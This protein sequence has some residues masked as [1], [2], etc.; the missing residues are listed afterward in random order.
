M[1]VA[2][3]KVS[4]GEAQETAP[5]VSRAMTLT[6]LTRSQDGSGSLRSLVIALG[7]ALNVCSR[8]L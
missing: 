5:A 6:V 8:L 4:G 2:V 3:V 7:K 1:R